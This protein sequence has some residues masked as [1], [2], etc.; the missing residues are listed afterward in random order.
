MSE[1]TNIQILSDSRGKPAF[2]VI[3]YDQ[4]MNREKRGGRAVPNEVVGNVIKHDMSPVRA[5]REHFG[6][7]QSEVAGRM[8]ISQ[9]AYAKQENARRVRKATRERIATALGIAPDMLNF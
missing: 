7:T 5:W 6:L 3:P 8:G 2:V 1:P 9:P 4:Y